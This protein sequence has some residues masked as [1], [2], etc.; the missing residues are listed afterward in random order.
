MFQFITNFTSYIFN[1]KNSK[2]LV[3]ENEAINL[4]FSM[5]WYRYSGNV[6]VDNLRLLLSKDVLNI[7]NNNSNNNYNDNT[8]N[9]SL[10]K[11]DIF[12][13][14]TIF[15]FSNNQYKLNN[16]FNLSY[17]SKC[18]NYDIMY[19]NR[20]VYNPYTSYTKKLIREGIPIIYNK[21]YLHYYF[22][23]II[24][25]YN[26]ESTEIFCS[27]YNSFIESIFDCYNTKGLGCYYPCFSAKYKQLNILSNLYLNNSNEN[28]E[29]IINNSHISILKED[30][31]MK[32][33]KEILWILNIIQHS[34]VSKI[35]FI[36]NKCINNIKQNNSNFDNRYNNTYSNKT[37][38]NNFKDIIS[39]L[40]NTLNTFIKKVSND[41]NNNIHDISNNKKMSNSNLNININNNYNNNKFVYCPLIP[42]TIYYILI[43]L[44]KEEA[45]IL[46]INLINKKPINSSIRFNFYKS[47]FE[48][49]ALTKAFINSLNY[50]DNS[51]F[52]LYIDLFDKIN[53]DYYK[54]FERPFENMFLDWFDFQIWN[55]IMLIFINEGI[56]II[57]R[58][59][60]AVLVYFKNEITSSLKSKFSCSEIYN[61]SIVSSLDNKIKLTKIINKEEINFILILNEIKLITN[62][63]KFEDSKELFDIA[64]NYSLTT[65]NNHVSDS[66]N[67]TFINFKNS[68]IISNN[69]LLLLNL[70][71]NSSKTCFTN[72][73]NSSDGFINKKNKNMLNKSINKKFY[74]NRYYC[75]FS[76]KYDLNSMIIIESKLYEKLIENYFI[77]KNNKYINSTICINNEIDIL[78]DY[79][80]SENKKIIKVNKINNKVKYNFYMLDDLHIQSEY[81]FLI[82]NIAPNYIRERKLFIKDN[83]Y[84]IKDCG[85]NNTNALNFD[86]D[87]KVKKPLNNSNSNSNKNIVSSDTI[88]N[89]NL[90]NYN[91]INVYKN[92]VKFLVENRYSPII[93]NIKLNNI[94]NEII[95]IIFSN[96]LDSQ[97]DISN[98]INKKLYLTE[99]LKY[100]YCYRLHIN[101]TYKKMFDSILCKDKYFASI[102]DNTFSIY[103]CNLSKNKKKVYYELSSLKLI[104][105]S[106]VYKNNLYMLNIIDDKID[107]INNNEFKRLYI[108]YGTFNL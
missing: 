46:L 84:F 92:L 45:L 19:I 48:K 63:L 67:K 6:N 94:E 87:I 28:I 105:N 54:L 101:K 21:Q 66:F 13:N 47:E 59:M 103:S 83:I 27:L 93:F 14:K 8:N 91:S 97:I 95:T 78:Y 30:T 24:Y 62:S 4:F 53:I 75:S 64:F 44:T 29:N 80:S 16:S 102:I 11:E 74:Y 81:L 71:D 35:S 17:F 108:E 40:A 9:I 50:I 96:P 25:K 33:F 7:N 38:S 60:Y 106:E 70:E 41:N 20:D 52:N 37:N 26:N 49:I 69:K 88:N 86:I 82:Y 39:Y 2:S 65:S 5:S 31:G 32:A 57:F 76:D 90:T 56:K 104:K 3:S 43:F 36:L 12:I 18:I 79:Y 73:T 77:D 98:N 34:E 89:I 22:N 15:N 42:I 58:I 51:L 72:S 23:N 1:N 55:K 68:N 99:E 85:L 61:S 107:I 10:S 100:I